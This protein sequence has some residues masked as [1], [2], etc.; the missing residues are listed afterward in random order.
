MRRRAPRPRAPSSP[1]PATRARSPLPSTCA[2]RRR[3]S[4]RRSR[5]ARAWSS[6]SIGPSTIMT[7]RL[8]SMLASRRH[9]TS[10]RSCTSTSLS[11]TPMHL[12]NMS[13]PMPHKPVHDLPPVERVLLVDRDDHQV[14]E[15]ALDRQVHV[16]DLGKHHRRSGRNS[17]SVALPSHAS[18]IGGRPTRVAGYT[19]SRRRV[20]P[21]D[22]E[23]G[24]LVARR[25]VA[26]VIAERP[27][28]DQRLR[29]VD[30]PLEH[31][32]GVGGDL[33]RHRLARHQLHRAPSQE[34]GE[35]PLVDAVGQRRG[36][37]VRERGIAAERDGDGSRRP[38]SFYL[39]KWRAPVL[40]AC[41]CIAVVLRVE[42]LHAV[43]AEVARAGL[44][45]V[46]DD[47]AAA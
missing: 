37:G 3:P 26:R 4:C 35:H 36:G 11:T 8:G 10:A 43:H 16:D 19:A 46:R 22:V 31:E 15:R 41:Q 29:R 5:P 9:A 30:V 28:V 39:R 24:I 20:T 21:G 6:W 42:L 47:D 7:S 18:S 25:V 12:E 27:L 33:E 14:V 17:R 34:P 38:R 32:V 23:R 1:P 13:C 45:I 40:C 44:G 2:S